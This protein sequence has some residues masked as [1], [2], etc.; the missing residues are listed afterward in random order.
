MLFEEWF[1]LISVFTDGTGRS[2]STQ[3]LL[4]LPYRSQFLRISKGYFYL[5]SSYILQLLFETENNKLK[6]T[7]SA[8]CSQEIE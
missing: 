5:L 8:D 1:R 4:N 3:E 7:I 6:V 2:K